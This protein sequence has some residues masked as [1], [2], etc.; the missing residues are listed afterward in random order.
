MHRIQ[1]G[2]I[3]KPPRYHFVKH[4]VREKPPA[5]VAVSSAV[6]AVSVTERFRISLV[7]ARSLPSHA[8]F[9]L[10]SFRTIMYRLKARGPIVLINIMQERDTSRLYSPSGQNYCIMRTRRPGAQNFIRQHKFP[11]ACCSAPVY[12]CSTLN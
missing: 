11:T 8:F 12:R 5:A 9:A 2:H 6:W 3:R 4:P 1:Q 10:R 7:C